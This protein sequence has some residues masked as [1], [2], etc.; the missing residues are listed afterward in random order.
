MIVIRRPSHRRAAL[1][2]VL[3]AG[4]L[5]AG[6]ANVSTRPVTPADPRAATSGTLSVGIT[7]PGSVDPTNAYEPMGELVDSVLC[8]PLIEQNPVT[9]ALQPGLASSWVVFN[10]GTQLDLRLRAGARFSNGAPVTAQDVVFT[11]SRLASANYASNEASLMSPVLG[12]GEIH[13]DIPTTN[14]VALRQL[15][16][17][18]ALSSHSVEIDLATPLAD[19][20]RALTTEA[21]APVSE[22]AANRAGL[23]FAADPICAGPYR[24]ATPWKAGE[25]TIVLVR[26]R[27]YTPSNPA[28]SDGGRG[29]ASRI[30]FHIFA[31]VPA[32]ARALAAGQV[33][34]APAPPPGTLRALPAG[35]SVLSVPGDMVEYVGFPTAGGTL[36]ARRPV[37]LALSEATD[38][39]ALIDAV[40]PGTRLPAGGFLT[41]NLGSV[42]SPDACGPTTPPGGNVAAAQATLAAAHISLRGAKIALY[43]NN[44]FRNVTFETALAHQWE[45]A[46]GMQVKVVSMTLPAFLAEGRSLSGFPG[47]FRFSWVPPYPS[48]EEIF[49]PLFTTSGIGQDNF[50]RFSDA[51]VDHELTRFADQATDSADRLVDLRKVQSLLCAQLPMVPL[52]MTTDRWLVDTARVGATRRGYLDRATGAPDLPELFLRASTG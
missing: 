4:I 51:A 33:Q 18:V 26:S 49:A 1:V 6:C 52:T 42:Y 16:G 29:Y 10:H 37:R 14:T 41:P 8:E 46:F 21:T 27:Y 13:G 5:L 34:L 48:A 3:A 19:F 50:A 15:A 43:V 39:R 2:V 20:V 22:Q 36:L 31:N 28:F 11:L 17:V 12:Y 32:A 30:I 9:G 23:S 7:M 47:A 38:R 45:A 44:N 40:Y 35:V 25:S 24:L